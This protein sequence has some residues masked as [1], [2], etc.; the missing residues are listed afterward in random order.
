MPPFTVRQNL[1][2]LPE[3]L[4]RDEAGAVSWVMLVRCIKSTGS[5]FGAQH[6]VP[7]RMANPKVSE[8]I[9]FERSQF[10]LLED[11]RPRRAPLICAVLDTRCASCVAQRR[12]NQWLSHRGSL[13]HPAS[14][15]PPGRGGSGAVW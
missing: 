4:W 8:D 15:K 11:M 10:L 9:F 3:S 1:L 6:F 14:Y 13:A 2:H 12:C 7:N 5:S